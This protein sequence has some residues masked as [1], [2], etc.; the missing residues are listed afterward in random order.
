MS[1]WGLYPTLHCSSFGGCQFHKYLLIPYGLHVL[2]HQKTFRPVSNP[3]GQWWTSIDILINNSLTCSQQ[4]NEKFQSLCSGVEHLTPQQKALS[5]CLSNNYKCIYNYI[6]T[7]QQQSGPS[8]WKGLEETM[9]FQS[10]RVDCG[11]MVHRPRLC[12]ISQ[13]EL[14]RKE[15][16][17]EVD[18]QIIAASS[19]TRQHLD[20]YILLIWK[21]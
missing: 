3:T 8:D 19:K 12:G 18:V 16:V 2:L 14:I 9:C 6:M 5:S 21:I 13:S 11:H 15:R 10:G 20:L 4:R 17:I 7:L 1:L